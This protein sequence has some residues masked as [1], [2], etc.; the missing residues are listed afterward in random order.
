M[1]GSSARRNGARSRLPRIATASALALSIAFGGPVAWAQ[2]TSAPTTGATEAPTSTPTE[3]PAETPAESPADQPTG[4]PADTPAAPAETPAETPAEAP[5]D[6]PADTPADSTPVEQPAGAPT[7]QP[8]QQTPAEHR[9]QAERVE[10]EAAP[11]VADLKVTAAFD[12]AEY[13]P[14]SAMGVTVTVENKGTAPASDVRFSTNGNV[15]FESGGEQLRRIPGP[16]LVP[17]ERLTYQLVVKQS[18]AR[19]ST[20]EFSVRVTDGLEQY[21]EADPTPQ[22]NYASTTAQVPQGRGSVIG[23]VYADHNGN[24]QPDSG[25]GVSGKSL[26]ATGG[27]PFTPLGARTGANGEFS[28]TDVPTGRYRAYFTT[29]DVV[30]QPGSSEF[31][32]ENGVTRTVAIQVGPPVSNVLRASVSLDRDSYRRTDP[33]TVQVSVTNTG[34]K[35]LTGVVAVCNP[36]NSATTLPGTAPGWA[37]LNPDGP[38]VAL[39]PGETKS[40][41]VADVVPDAA[42]HAGQL[43]VSCNFGNNGRNVE[44]Y[45]GSSDHAEVIGAFGRVEGV[46]LRADAN[47][48]EA[49]L[50]GARLI[51]LDR[52][53]GLRAYEATSDGA[54]RWSFPKLPIGTNEVLVLGA[55]RAADGG[56]HVVEVSSDQTA[57]ARFVVVDGPLVTEPRHAPDIRVTASFDKASYDMVEPIRAT[58]RITNAGTGYG[59]SIGLRTE[60]VDSALSYDPAQWGDLRPNQSTPT[61]PSLWPGEER[62]I[63][64]VGTYPTYRFNG[65]VRLK[66]TIVASDTN[67][68]DNVIDISAAVTHSTGD[69]VAL[70]YGDRNGNGAFDQGEELPGVQV[71]FEGGLPRK[72]L[73]GR[74]DASGRFRLEDVPAG[75][76]KLFLYSTDD[77]WITPEDLY[78]VVTVKAGQESSAEFRLVRPLSDKLE[79]TLS[80]DRPSYRPGEQPTLTGTL[81]NNTGAPITVMA[82]CGGYGW[83]YEIANTDEWGPLAWNGPGIALADGETRAFHVVETMPEASPDHGLVLAS[84][85]FGPAGLPNGSPLV[86]ATAEVPGAVWTTPGQVVR[87]GEGGNVGVGGVELVLLDPR[88]GRVAARTVTDASGGFTFPDLAVGQYTP[89]VLG[90]WR[91]H[92]VHEGPLFEAVRGSLWPRLVFV[93]PGPEV[94]DPGPVQPEPVAP[95]QP[96]DFTGSTSGG[97]SG[98]TAGGFSGGGTSGGSAA[99]AV[100]LADTGVSVIALGLFGLLALALGV[101]TRVAAGIRR[102]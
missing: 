71:G 32:V 60:Y 91:V 56:A 17:G 65:T 79:V 24:G 14:E 22:D 10:A 77:G 46:L 99:P 90:P 21:P 82:Y 74:T 48:V 72:W 93:E 67:Q 68:A 8:A 63:T 81:T 44:G 100:G 23:V 45:T 84:C 12:R 25:E 31:A 55:Y 29:T 18:Y 9:A 61:S 62:V 76:Y 38:G 1:S 102:A 101:G 52:R 4:N 50:P 96:A 16:G 13:A 41:T 30:V 7:D 19:D 64:L 70:I 73:D 98:G 86:R 43:S 2:E 6:T 42:Y 37:P 49:P 27:A 57:Q 97:F 53:S 28:F 75:H 58:V 95:V 94:A 87:Q 47:G 36:W 5:A 11:L 3:P 35:P 78:R 39:E 89:V 54:G 40:F 51:A 15:W 80:F 34:T 33:V 92:A 26:Q 83:A 69:A 85:Y 66:A 59:A 88:S 20:A